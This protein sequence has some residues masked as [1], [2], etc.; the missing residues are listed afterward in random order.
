MF[1]FFLING[2]KI[3]KK[4]IRNKEDEIIIK[5]EIS[6][7]LSK[8]IKSINVFISINCF[9]MILSWYYISCLNNVY[10][11]TKIEWI[12]S[13]IVI[14]ILMKYYLYILLYILLRYISIKY[15]IEKIYKLIEL[16][17]I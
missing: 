10:P 17:H 2:D 9:I 15:K 6:N 3:R 11:N 5:G 1:A 12:K 7:N 16:F 13:S 8:I 4:L 14:L